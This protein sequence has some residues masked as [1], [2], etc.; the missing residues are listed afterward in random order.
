YC[1][2]AITATN[3]ST[4]KLDAL[5]QDFGVLTSTDNLQSAADCDVIVLCVKPQIM[6]QVCTELAA[7]D[8]SS[9]LVM[10]IAAGVLSDRY[11]S[12]CK[13][14]LA[15][16]RAMPNT[17]SQIGLGMTGLYASAGVTAAQRDLCEQMLSSIGKVLWVDSEDKLNLVIALAGS[18]PAYFFLFI[19]AM[20]DAAVKLGM[21]ADEAR[22]LAQ[23]AALGSAVMLENN[24]DISLQQ[25]RQN[26][27]SKG[28]TTHEAIVTFE[29][30][31]LRTLVDEAMNNAIKRAD[32]MA[33]TF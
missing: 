27:T 33:A 25:L 29:Q 30:G 20:V 13:Q 6:Q 26:V 17:P 15:L 10:T 14:P 4:P 31:G 32:A 11:P 7:I 28:G 8:L 21:N 2:Q 16:I 5:A 1:P 22:L 23:Q 19:E 24:P 12:Y 3:P 9:K 18:S